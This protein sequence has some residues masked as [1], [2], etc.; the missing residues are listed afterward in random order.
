MVKTKIVKSKEYPSVEDLSN[1]QHRVKYLE[2]FSEIDQHYINNC[3]LKLEEQQR[4]IEKHKQTICKRG[5]K[6]KKLKRTKRDVYDFAVKL[7]QENKL[8]KTKLMEKDSMI[9]ID[10]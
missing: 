8:L 1:M 3:H 5:I 10:E 9:V 7:L 2:D 4:E 6:I